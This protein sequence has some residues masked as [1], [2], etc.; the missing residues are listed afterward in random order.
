MANWLNLFNLLK[1]SCIAKS[2]VGNQR[3]SE[4]TFLVRYS[5][6]QDNSAT[7]SKNVVFR[8]RRVKHL[9][10]AGNKGTCS[11][12]HRN[13]VFKLKLTRLGATTETFLVGAF[14][15]KTVW[16][17]GKEARWS[18]LKKQ[19]NFVLSEI[20]LNSAWLA[21]N[22]QKTFFKCPKALRT[23]KNNLIQRQKR[24][25]TCDKPENSV[26]WPNTVTYSQCNK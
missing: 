11:W 10:K 3:R 12:G 23:L 14:K 4:K 9:N 22:G 1:I 8:E 18:S 24:E 6:E 7:K 17:S 5:W 20:K 13:N 25:K 26:I 21:A 19:R 15:L 16:L 2:S